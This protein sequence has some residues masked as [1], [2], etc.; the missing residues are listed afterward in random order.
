MPTTKSNSSK[1]ILTQDELLSVIN[2]DFEL[3]DRFVTKLQGTIKATFPGIGGLHDTLYGGIVDFPKVR[4]DEFIQILHDGKDHWVTVYKSPTEDY[5]RIYDTLDHRQD[6]KHVICCISSL[7]RTDA[8]TFSYKYKRVQVQD[9]GT[10]CG[11]F[12]A[13]IAVSLAFG[14]NPSDVK[15]ADDAALRNHLMNI[16]VSGTVTSFPKTKGFVKMRREGRLKTV[17]VYC[18]CRLFDYDPLFD[19]Q[20]NWKKQEMLRK[21]GP[22]AIAEAKAKSEWNWIQCRNLE[23]QKWFHWKCEDVTEEDKMGKTKWLCRACR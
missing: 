4:E 5:V 10:N 22:N 21:R 2:P 3:T 17:E 18:Y 16:F 13:A 15:Y 12:A 11:V 1:I 9:T 20:G 19:N 7:L 14:E 6:T 23:C 8:A